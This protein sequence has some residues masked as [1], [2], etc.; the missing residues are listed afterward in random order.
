MTAF[1][2]V[3]PPTNARLTVHRAGCAHLR[4]LDSSQWFDLRSLTLAAA[5]AEAAAEDLANDPDLGAPE[6]VVV[7][8]ACARKA[9]K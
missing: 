8:A 6:D 7:V 1:V 9:A 3:T 5:V 4:R 2:C